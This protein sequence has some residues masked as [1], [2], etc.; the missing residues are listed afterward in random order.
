MALPPVTLTPMIGAP[1]PQETARQISMRIQRAE[2]ERRAAPAWLWAWGGDAAEGSLLLGKAMAAF[3]EYRFDILG[4]DALA[5]PRIDQRPESGVRHLGPLRELSRLDGSAY[6]GIVLAGDV[7]LAAAVA[8]RAALLGLPVVAPATEEL[9]E[10]MGEGGACWY[11]WTPS[12][13]LAEVGEQPGKAV[14]AL[15]ALGGQELERM[16]LAAADTVVSWSE[17][18]ASGRALD[19]LFGG[20]LD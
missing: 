17:Y 4:S 18:P 8:A 10:T 14:A 9:L 12:D 3:P 6:S 5:V 15:A 7:E 19:E 1:D 11:R 16:L 2:A 20:S 13:L